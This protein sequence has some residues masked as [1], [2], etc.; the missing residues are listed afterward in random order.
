M[1]SLRQLTQT[2]PYMHDGSLET[3]RNVVD[4]YSNIDLNRIHSDGTLI[5]SSL[6]LT[7]QES[8]DLVAFL[9]SLST[10]LQ[11]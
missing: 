6:N 2:S 4:H 8:E 1:P 5:L 11:K 10:P 3:L 7:E 9:E